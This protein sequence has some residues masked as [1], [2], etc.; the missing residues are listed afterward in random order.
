MFV[1]SA[2]MSNHD[3]D[4]KRNFVVLKLAVILR[5]FA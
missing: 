2:A 4:K 1:L 3:N 5:S